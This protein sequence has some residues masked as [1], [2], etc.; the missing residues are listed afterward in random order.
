MGPKLK[1]I[2]WGV[3]MADDDFVRV[4]RPYFKQQNWTLHVAICL[5]QKT[6]PE[7]KKLFVG[8]HVLENGKDDLSCD[9][10]T[11]R[12]FKLAMEAINTHTVMH[13]R[14]YDIFP[15]P[16]V[17]AK[18]DITSAKDIIVN[19]RRFIRWVKKTWPD[20]QSHLSLAEVHYQINKAKKLENIKSENDKI[21]W[22]MNKE[23]AEMNRQQA[24]QFFHDM[25]KSECIDLNEKLSVKMLAQDLHSAMRKKIRNPYSI[26][27]L[28]QCMIPEFITEYHKKS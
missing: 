6:D 15:L 7:K 10:G 25:I 1:K 18:V 28:R 12:I 17:F 23:N 4:S 13:T 20:G 2:K 26:E 8:Q 16:M 5:L 27:T 19:P 3:G 9:D 14:Y 24:K 21:S 22:K 11:D